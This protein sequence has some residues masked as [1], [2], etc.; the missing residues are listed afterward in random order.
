MLYGFVG[1]QLGWTLRPFFG[2]PDRPFVIFRAIEGNF[3][4]GVIE[5]IVRLFH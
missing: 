1:T 2:D 5:A 4:L 3:Y